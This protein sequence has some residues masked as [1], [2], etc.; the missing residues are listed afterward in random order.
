V[1]IILLCVK[2]PLFEDKQGAKFG[3]V[4]WS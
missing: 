4:W 2:L 1:A 3:R